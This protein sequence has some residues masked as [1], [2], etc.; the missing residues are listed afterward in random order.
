MIYRL[1]R[2]EA[3]L[4]KHLPEVKSRT[5]GSGQVQAQKKIRG[6][7]RPSEDRP[8][9]GQGQGSSRPRTKNTTWKYSPKKRPSL[10]KKRKVSAKFKRTQKKRDKYR[11]SLKKN[12]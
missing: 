10:K 3:N 9:R 1:L 12:K 4:L 7:D 8:S 11:S 2:G 5:Q 6:K